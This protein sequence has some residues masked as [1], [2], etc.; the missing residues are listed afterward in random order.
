MQFKDGTGNKF[1]GENRAV[2]VTQCVKRQWSKARL[3]SPYPRIPMMLRT[4]KHRER[5][6]RKLRFRENM[7]RAASPRFFNLESVFEA[8]PNCYFCLLFVVF[9]VLFCLLK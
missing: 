2:V 8:N 4:R 9:T 1:K 6:Q 7:K 5:L 3:D